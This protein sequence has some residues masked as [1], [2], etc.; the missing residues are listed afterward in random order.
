LLAE[1]ERLR[2]ENSALRRVLES[3]VN[4][5]RGLEERLAELEALVERLSSEV[6]ELESRCEALSESYLQVLEA[7]RRLAE[8]LD[9]LRYKLAVPCNYTLMEIGEF[10]RAVRFAY[11]EEMVRYVHNITGG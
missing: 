6:S 1:R 2:S 5:R 9:R 10:L 7:N 8:E 4:E 3:L 11:S